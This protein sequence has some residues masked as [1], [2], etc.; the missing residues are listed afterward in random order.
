MPNMFSRDKM[1]FVYKRWKNL[2]ENQKDKGHD[3]YDN[4]VIAKMI[5]NDPSGRLWST[6]S[7]YFL[8]ISAIFVHVSFENNFFN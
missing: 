3:S 2:T 1:L 5:C 7:L 6:P 4:F 8:R